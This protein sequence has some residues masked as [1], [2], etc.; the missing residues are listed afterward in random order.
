MA[1]RD[2]ERASPFAALAL[3]ASLLGLEGCNVTALDR[4]IY[5]PDRNV[6]A[7]P[8]GVSERRFTTA[9]GVELHAWYAPAADGR[10]AQDAPTLVWSHGNGG[11]IAWREDVLLALAAR[12]LNVLAY[13]YRGYGRSTGRPS[14]AGVELDAEAAYDLLA[15]DGVPPERIVAFGESLGGAVSITLARRRP[16]AAVIVVSTF[17]RLRDVAR[18]HYGTLAMLAGNQF[19]STDNVRRLGV[20]ILVAHGD[21]D[22]IVPYALGEQLYALAAGEKRFLRVAGAH[23]NDVFEDPDLLDAIAAFAHA[24]AHTAPPPPSGG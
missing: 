21:R 8:P 11:N 2:V 13:D 22:E 6:P 23:H 19:D 4:L 9:D 18:A 1:R 12:G 20:P 24:A 16:C 15:R 14:Q 7:P 10:P 3:V 5:F 17:P